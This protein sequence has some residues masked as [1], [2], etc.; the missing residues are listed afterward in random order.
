MTP[1]RSGETL[2]YFRCML[3]LSLSLI[4]RWTPYLTNELGVLKK[5]GL[6]NNEYFIEI[7][8]S[9]DSLMRVFLKSCIK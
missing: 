4:R 5:S 3:P 6:V 2:K 7:I 8:F 1:S 9:I